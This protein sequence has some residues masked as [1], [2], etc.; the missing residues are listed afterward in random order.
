MVSKINIEGMAY[1]LMDQNLRLCCAESCTGGAFAKAC[2]DVAGSSTWFEGGVVVYSNQAKSSLLGIEQEP[3][4]Q[5]GA[6]SKEI[7]LLMAEG[8]LQKLPQAGVSVAVSGIAGP[9]GGTRAKPVGLVW[10]A[11]QQRGER[12]HAESYQFTGSRAQVREQSIEKMLAGILHLL[13]Q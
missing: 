1:T 9:S 12:G 2:T 7:V 13:P 8:I 3:L 6:V 11:W 5:Y 10:L 4:L